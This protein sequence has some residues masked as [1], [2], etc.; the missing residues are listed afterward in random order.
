MVRYL[1]CYYADSEGLELPDIKSLVLGWSKTPSSNNE[2]A[3]PD[4]FLRQFTKLP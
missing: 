2:A 3:A 1:L 4:N